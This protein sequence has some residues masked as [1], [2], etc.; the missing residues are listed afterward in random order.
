MFEMQCN[1]YLMDQLTGGRPVDYVQAQ[2]RSWISDDPKQIQLVVGA[3]LELGIS[4]F[5]GQG[6]N[7]STI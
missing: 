1:E 7:N 2:L 3:G 5:Q 6:P 4:R